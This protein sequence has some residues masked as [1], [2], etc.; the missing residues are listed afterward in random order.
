M[1]VFLPAEATKRCVSQEHHLYLTYRGLRVVQARAIK[2]SAFRVR[3]SA[4]RGNGAE[5]HLLRDF[6]ALHLPGGLPE[7]ID[8]LP[9]S[10][11]QGWIAG[12]PLIVRPVVVVGFGVF[13]ISGVNTLM[14]KL[15]R[16][17]L[18]PGEVFKHVEELF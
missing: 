12:Q 2:R 18:R 10:G 14:E 8:V 5:V 3:L 7:P 4:I 9:I 15:R 13:L 11:R 6:P 16:V 1:I 17:G